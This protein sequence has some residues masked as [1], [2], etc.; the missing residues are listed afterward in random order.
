MLV[1]SRLAG[2]RIQIGPDIVLT[3]VRI[4]GNRVSLGIEAP[5]NV[6]VLRTEIVEDPQPK[7]AVDAA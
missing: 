7:T 5:D 4:F 3:V 2:E 1:L 6:T